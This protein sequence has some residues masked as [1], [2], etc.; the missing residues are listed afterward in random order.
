MYVLNCIFKEKKTQQVDFWFSMMAE[1]LRSKL[2]KNG[3]KR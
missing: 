1:N 2:S 3:K